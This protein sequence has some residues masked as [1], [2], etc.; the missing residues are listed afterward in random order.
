MNETEVS[1]GTIDWA[2][3]KHG[4]TLWRIGEADRLAAGFKLA[5]APRAYDNFLKSPDTLDFTIGKS[6]EA[7]WFYCQRPKSNYRIHF[8]VK[9]IEGD[10]CYLSLATD[11]KSVV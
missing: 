10:S 11:R 5:D 1:L 8:K 6:K 4:K 7:D 2:P 3:L 9:K